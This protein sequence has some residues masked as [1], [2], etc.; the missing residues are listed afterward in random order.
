MTTP[1]EASEFEQSAP[2]SAEALGQINSIMLDHRMLNITR[3]PIEKW[4][5]PGAI[6]DFVVSDDVN[7]MG[8]EKGMDIQFTFHMMNDQFMVTEIYPQPPGTFVN[9][10]NQSKIDNTVSE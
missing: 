9:E 1:L 3:G 10:S 7:M 6:A 2:S 4:G 5:R 8:L